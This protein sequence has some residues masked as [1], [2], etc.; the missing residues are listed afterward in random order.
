MPCL[1]AESTSIEV[2]I[3]NAVLVEELSEATWQYVVVALAP[4]QIIRA[5]RS[6][7]L[8]FIRQ[9]I[10]VYAAYNNGT[11]KCTCLMLWP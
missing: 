7:Y 6:W 9:V 10:L 5:R 11:S 1:L 8:S 2:N 4:E 3:L